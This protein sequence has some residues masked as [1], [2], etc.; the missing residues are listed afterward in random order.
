MDAREA[1]E[2]RHEIERREQ[3]RKEEL[4]QKEQERAAQSRK[5]LGLLL[6]MFDDLVQSDDHRRQ[7]CF[8]IY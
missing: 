5:E 2:R 6:M 8:R 7:N 1:E 4:A 3:E